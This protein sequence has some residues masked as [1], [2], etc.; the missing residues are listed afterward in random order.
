MPGDGRVMRRLDTVLKPRAIETSTRV[1]T[2]ASNAM[3]R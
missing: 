3:L 2:I 1:S